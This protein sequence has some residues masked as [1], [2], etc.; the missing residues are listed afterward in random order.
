[1]IVFG[2]NGPINETW[3]LAMVASPGNIGTWSQIFPGGPPSPRRQM[4]AILDPVRRRM[5]MFGGISDSPR[6]D[7][8]SLSLAGPPT[9]TQLTP[10][11]PYPLPRRGH[12]AVYDPVRDRMIVFG[13]LSTSGHALNDVWSLSLSG[14]P[15]WTELSPSGL[16]P[17]ERAGCALIYDPVR[18]RLVLFA[19]G[20]LHPGGDFNDV[21]QLSL[22]GPP[23]WT[24]LSPSGTAPEERSWTSAIYDPVRD[25]MVIF[26]GVGY[27]TDP[28]YGGLSYDN[29]ADV[30]SLDLAGGTSW[31]QLS[32]TGVGPGPRY[33][34]SIVH[35][36]MGDRLVDFGGLYSQGPSCYCTNPTHPVD[37]AVG[38]TYFLNW[39]S[40]TSTIDVAPTTLEYGPVTIDLSATR[41]VTVTN[42]R[43][44]SL[45]VSNVA[46][47]DPAVTVSPTAFT[48]APGESRIVAVQWSPTSP[49]TLATTVVVTS[50]DSVHP[51][52][53]ISLNGTAV[54]TVPGLVVPDEL[55]LGTAYVDMTTTQ[56]MV[57]TNVGSASRTVSN[58]ASADPTLSASPTAF[59]LAHG[60]SQSVTLQWAP[61]SPGPLAAT[62]EVA[63]NDPDAPTQTIDVGGTA[64]LAP[65]SAVTPE[66]FSVTLQQNQTTTRTL[67]IDNTG[68]GTLDFNATEIAAAPNTPSV[69]TATGGRAGD[70]L[71]PLAAGGPDVFGYTYRDSDEPGGPPFSW[72]D[73]RS[74][75]T[76]ILA[77]GDNLNAGFFPIG[78]SFPFFG[79]QFTMFRM[80]TNGWISFTN[81]TSASAANVALPNAAGGVPEN[82]LAVFWDDLDF[83]GT[84]RA[85]YH[86]NGSRLVVQYQDV[87]RVGEPGSSNTFE[88]VLTPDG[89]ILYQYDTMSSFVGSAT[90]G[91]QNAT[92]D[93][94][95]QVSFNQNYV[96]NGLAIRFTHPADFLK[97]SPLSGSVGPGGHVDLTLTF[98]STG[99][100]EGD[101]PATV[102][103]QSNDPNTPTRDIPCLLTVATPVGVPK[104]VVERFGLRLAGANP[105]A[106]GMRLELAV[107][108]PSMVVVRVFDVHGALVRE[109]ARHEFVAGVHPVAWDG[110]DAEGRPARSGVYFVQASGPDGGLNQRVVLLR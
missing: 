56:T 58:I 79:N 86:T 77:A 37:G 75:G 9:W 100:A 13:G 46:T 31:Q 47:T 17:A 68:A 91:I 2:G 21:W 105:S 103:I 97:V 45:T 4:S 34:T 41:A 110:A 96:H 85:W 54:E 14:S 52:Q 49:G 40:P 27:Y 5:V 11:G 61:T 76:Q 109:L 84:P 55:Q 43:S 3:Q 23:A 94:A 29:M 39:G 16:R 73:I 35:D 62:F 48:L 87:R 1:M 74:M 44:A 72:I 42:F 33:S 65:A 99:L 53:T 80:S 20:D 50:D 90:V 69:A 60:Q 108:K 101:Y 88:V 22:T 19:G 57:V 6:N 71:G 59:T 63:S 28:Y 26:G 32:P 7:V 51:T 25:R 10:T 78:F 67:R 24:R 106:G 18:D 70:R 64:A 98:N 83:A 102:Q 82:L 93:D 104:Q 8:W 92:R 81:S 15:T 12:G 107:P 30:Q 38:A 89:S 66:S 36:R 95:L